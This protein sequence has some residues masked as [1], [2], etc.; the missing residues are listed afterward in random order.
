MLRSSLSNLFVFAAAVP[1]FA[2]AAPDATEPAPV[3]PAYQHP[4]MT[5]VPP[6]GIS[7]SKNRLN[8]TF[9]GVTMADG[10]THLGL[11]FWTPT[12]E[13]GVA[14]AGP[15]DADVADFVKWGHDHGIRVLLCVYNGAHSWD[16]NLA[17]AGFAE[18]RDAFAQALVT[19]ADRLHL[20]GVD[21]DLEGN[22]SFEA[23]KVPFLDF[24]RNI[25]AKLHAEN[26]HLTVDSFSH[27]WNAPNSGWWKELFPFVDGLTT[28]GYES[29][30]AKAAD[31]KSYAGQKADAGEGA[32]KFM[33]GMPAHRDAWQGNTAAEQLAWVV[34]DGGVG[35][36]IWDAQLDNGAWVEAETWAA[37][38]KV[39]GKVRSKK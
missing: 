6:Y 36:S 12:K 7:K 14:Y 5:W 39:A 22:G 16:W 21:I 33:L 26:K 1:L 4:V 19:E 28:M 20:D 38:Q 15:T 30:G 37:L 8:Q 10:L 31:W 25:S 27:I 32:S 29:L 35:V 18:H 2:S 24:M 34:S 11:Q 17:R 3:F 9:D 23:D 13:G